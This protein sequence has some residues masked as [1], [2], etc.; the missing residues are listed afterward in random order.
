MRAR[1]RQTGHNVH[2]PMALRPAEAP[3]ILR[4]LESRHWPCLQAHP[5]P[6]HELCSA[7]FCHVNRKRRE[8][9]DRIAWV[10][11][12]VRT[13][14]PA[15]TQRCHAKISGSLKFFVLVPSPSTI[16]AVCLELRRHPSKLALHGPPTVFCTSSPPLLQLLTR[17]LPPDAALDRTEP[18]RGGWIACRHNSSQ[19]RDT[20]VRIRRSAM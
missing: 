11:S 19:L 9:S 8:Q 12:L 16:C 4:P 17:K 20:R 18:S 14:S 13:H 1:S 15:Q 5:C 6:G 2:T 10:A 3:D 7:F